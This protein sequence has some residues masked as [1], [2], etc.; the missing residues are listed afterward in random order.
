MLKDIVD[1]DKKF[2]LIATHSDN[3]KI[4]IDNL[5]Q[6]FSDIIRCYTLDDLKKQIPVLIAPP[7]FSSEWICIVQVQ[8]NT[9]FQYEKLVKKLMSS[10]GVF[11]F[12]V[13]SYQDYKRMKKFLPT[14]LTND[15][16]LYRLNK[17]D[18]NFIL[19]K[20]VIQLSEPVYKKLC[21]DYAKNIDALFALHE[22][23]V[24][25]PAVN[26]KTASEL[27]DICGTPDPDIVSW[28]LTLS[29]RLM[30][31][32][33]KYKE[34]SFSEWNI[35]S[36]RSLRTILSKILPLCEDKSPEYVRVCLKNCVGDFIQ[37]KQIYLQGDEP[38]KEDEYKKY[39]K[40]LEKIKK[41]PLDVLIFIY[42][43]L[44]E[45]EHWDTVEDCMDFIHHIYIH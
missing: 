13:G 4:F 25:N 24:S 29:T 8:K 35:S 15:A 20:Q 45:K 40:K 6:D 18:I 5:F 2:H 44:D 39:I 12:Y 31:A 19:G 41:I 21:R 34:K 17:L 9:G 7:F 27:L 1:S 30:E 16:Y 23:L 37:M 42:E 28:V 43:K 26:V 22:F 3:A 38:E 36:L 14:D 11:I 33:E 32:P 10:F